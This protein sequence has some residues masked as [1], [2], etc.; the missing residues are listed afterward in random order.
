MKTQPTAAAMRAAKELFPFDAANDLALRAKVVGMKA[1]IIDRETGLPEAIGALRL[2]LV[3]EGANLEEL[4]D[5]GESEDSGNVC[6]AKDCIAKY[7]AALAKLE[8]K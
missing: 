6:A 8:G 3:T 5:G 7:S 1:E 2:A 4:L